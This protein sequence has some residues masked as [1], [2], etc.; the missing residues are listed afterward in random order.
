MILEA[1]QRIRALERR[2][3]ALEVE[4]AALR[5]ARHPSEQPGSETICA[6]CHQGFPVA[7]LPAHQQQCEP[8]M[9]AARAQRKRVKR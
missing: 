3:D 4:N 6:W 8:F 2:V 9:Q 1:M 7:S 5:A